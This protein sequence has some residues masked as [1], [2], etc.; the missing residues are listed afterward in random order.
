[1]PIEDR[2][3]IVKIASHWVMQ[4]A[5]V[6]VTSARGVIGRNAVE[7]EGRGQEEVESPQAP[8]LL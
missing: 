4:G 8:L 5:D 6:K 7:A 1:M 3:Q 2:S